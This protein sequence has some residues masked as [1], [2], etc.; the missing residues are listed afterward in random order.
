MACFEGNQLHDDDFNAAMDMTEDG[1]LQNNE[2][3]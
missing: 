3:V 2:D 1:I